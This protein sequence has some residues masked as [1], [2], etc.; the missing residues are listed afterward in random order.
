MAR[1]PTD[2]QTEV[3]LSDDWVLVDNDMDDNEALDGAAGLD[4]SHEL[5]G[6]KPRPVP[7]EDV[8]SMGEVLADGSEQGNK[9]L[10]A[11]SDFVTSH[12]EELDFEDEGGGRG[13]YDD[14]HHDSDDYDSDE[15]WKKLKAEDLA[16]RMER[17]NAFWRQSR[18]LAKHGEY[19][20]N[21]AIWSMLWPNGRGVSPR[22]QEQG[23]AKGGGEVNE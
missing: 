17:D 9:E 19:G 13:F 21:N 2:E 23:D 8:G 20:D 10:A 3:A 12:E 15:E 16:M 14:E 1:V 7:E 18:I 4:G 22:A 11:A 6:V 5:S